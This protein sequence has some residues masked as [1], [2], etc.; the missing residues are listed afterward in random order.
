MLGETFNARGPA[1]LIIIGQGL[2]CLRAGVGYV[3]F[4]ILV[5]RVFSALEETARPNQNKVDWTVM[6]FFNFP[7]LQV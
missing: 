7:T 3:D 6:S 1:K 4:F 2:L 5:Y